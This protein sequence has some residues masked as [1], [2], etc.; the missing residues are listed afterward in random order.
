M[1]RTA[2]VALVP[3]ATV[4]DVGVM[5]ITDVA[6]VMMLARPSI[7][8]RLAS[9]EM[10]ARKWRG[11]LNFDNITQTPHTTFGR[12]TVVE[13]VSMLTYYPN[14]FVTLSIRVGFVQYI[15]ATPHQLYAVDVGH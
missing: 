9:T 8:T 6:A 10:A 11:P 3:C 7:K 5:E 1:I 13:Q 4:L 14:S 12:M 2:Y 15:G